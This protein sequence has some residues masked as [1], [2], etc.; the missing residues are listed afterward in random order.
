MD[1]LAALESIKTK[2]V[3][4]VGGDHSRVSAISKVISAIKDGEFDKQESAA[5]DQG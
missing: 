4:I 2:Q 1:A 3:E 5:I